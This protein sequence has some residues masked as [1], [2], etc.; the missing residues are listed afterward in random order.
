[1]KKEISIEE[2]KSYRCGVTWGEETMTKKM[3]ELYPFKSLNTR[4]PSNYIES[5]ETTVKGRGEVFCISV[6]L[7]FALHI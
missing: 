4:Q 7:H 5:L 2:R 6:K 3:C 1:M